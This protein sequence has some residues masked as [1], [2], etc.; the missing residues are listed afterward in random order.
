MTATTA[1]P[2]SRFVGVIPKDYE[3]HVTAAVIVVGAMVCAAPVMVLST[4]WH[5]FWTTIGIAL[6]VGFGFGLAMH[7]YEQLQRMHKANEN[8]GQKRGKR[9][10]AVENIRP[11]TTSRQ[12]SNILEDGASYLS[13]MASAGYPL[14]D[15][16]LRGQVLRQ[17]ES[18]WQTKYRFTDD[19]IEEQRAPQLLQEDWPGLPPPV[20]RELG[21]F[22]EHVMRD[23]ISGW[24]CKVDGGCVYRP[25]TDKRK[26]GIPRDGRQK[27]PDST[28]NSN[29]DSNPNDQGEQEKKQEQERE[30]PPHHASR[31]MVFS[32]QMH[33]RI[34]ML[35]QTY[36]VLSAS[37]GNLAT[38]AEH[39]NILSLGL[40]K[41]T[42][43]L[44]H[45]FKVYRLLRKAAEDKNSTQN[46]SEIQVTREFLLAGK[47]HRAV[48]FGLDVPSLLFADA[49]GD[50]CGTGTDEPPKNPNQVLEQR[51]FQTSIL[52][53]CEVDYNRVVAHR[54]VRA[55]LP[56]ADSSSQV[57]LALVVEIFAACVLQPL[58]NLWI[59]SF[60]NGL[61]VSAMRKSKTE[62]DAHK[63]DIDIDNDIDNSDANEVL[64]VANEVVNTM[65][66]GVTAIANSVNE[67]AEKLSEITIDGTCTSAAFQLDPLT[68]VSSVLDSVKE[69][70]SLTTNTFS[71]E[72]SILSIETD[73]DI[74]DE[75]N[76]RDEEIEMGE[77]DDFE[78]KN[79]T[80]LG[81]LILKI[82]SMSL[83][84]LQKYMDF[85][86]CR[87]ARANH[88]ENK[89]DWDDP[90]CQAAVLRLVMV[91][92]A[93][94]LQ[95]RCMYREPVKTNDVKDGT[96]IGRQESERSLAN[97]SLPQLLMEMTSDMNAFE[98]RVDTISEQG[99]APKLMDDNSVMDFEPEPSEVSTLRTLISTWLHTGQA[100]R[101]ISLIIKAHK[102]TFAPFYCNNEFLSVQRNAD[103]FAEHMKLL[104]GVDVMVETMAVL[105]SPRLDLEAES[106]LD[107]SSSSLAGSQSC[108]V[109]S[110][111]DRKANTMTLLKSS[112][113]GRPMDD[114]VGTS[115]DV[116]AHFGSTS[117]PRYLDFHKN[118]AFASSL[119][120]ERERRMRSWETLKA[121]ETIQTVHRKSASPTDIELHHELHNLSR[122]FY[123]G[124][125]IMTIR[126]AARKSDNDESP[127]ES[128]A[129]GGEQEKV[130]LLTVEM[131]SNRRRIE[132]PDDDSSFLL[133]A[134]VRL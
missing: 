128:T 50:E 42:Q 89:V 107:A 90:A 33:R 26:Q 27:I 69:A 54:L 32:T 23:Y 102:N 85:E 1:D 92:E 93:A 14:D 39:V 19:T 4:I 124:T 97:D 61:I 114:Q 91:I 49:S 40:L 99:S 47:L 80:I 17:N 82:T 100:S 125:N 127:S 113:S 86:E 5:L 76:L 64:E 66:D 72:S 84:D 88:Q 79:A 98:K 96:E 9:R 37:F 78:E 25:E 81:D 20:T 2:S 56:R 108:A 11:K 126:D 117:T 59:P 35:D 21:R 22:V 6:G 3:K 48:T 63:I 12:S 119:R 118:S 41:W 7:V 38:R 109:G 112:F 77:N 60:L 130:S 28:S 36:R 106:D 104:D 95:G 46:P 52:K 74:V 111:G 123:N 133:R 44:A 45:T 122:I 30:Q 120:A 24:Y 18:F 83:T 103:G 58:M 129:G 57:V 68:T 15:K 71:K 10:L 51:L 55:L 116:M 73:G 110:K 101:A 131:V 43:V 29:S 134:Q 94:L 31:K 105:A 13:L 75:T 62:K 121:D 8:E 70:S 65:A 115:N 34:P 53:E 132:V 16:V 87:L 67:A